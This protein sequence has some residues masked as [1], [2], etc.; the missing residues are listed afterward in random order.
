[1]A[2]TAKNVAAATEQVVNPNV[3]T[4]ELS[5]RDAFEAMLDGNVNYKRML[6][7][8]SEEIPAI[9]VD[10]NGDHVAGTRDLID[11][12][13]SAIIRSA[14]A[15]DE[16]FRF[17]VTRQED[18]CLGE[19]YRFNPVALKTILRGATIKFDRTF[20]R[21]GDVYEVDGVQM[22]REFDGYF[23]DLK[24]VKFEGEFYEELIKKSKDYVLDEVF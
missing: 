15:T 9:V 5:V 2:K 12:P 19:P 1:M 6:I 13:V 7:S 14:V 18:K 21:A 24:E 17:I 10:N 23:T 11:V 3:T 20:K 16:R 22:Q 4:Y 8:L